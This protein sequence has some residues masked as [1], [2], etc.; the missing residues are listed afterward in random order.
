MKKIKIIGL[1]SVA[2]AAL[3]MSGCGGKN[4]PGHTYMPDMGY[5]RAYETYAGHDSTVITTNPADRG[6]KA[7]FY[8]AMPVAGT[9]KRGELFP[10]TLP[11]DTTGY[12][13]SAKVENPLK[14]M[15]VI[16]LPE[17]ERL[18]MINCAICHGE[19]AAGYGP[20][21]TSGKVPGIANLT[22]PLY[23]AMADGT[24]FHSITYGK[25]FMGSYASQL[26]RKQ[27]WMVI[28]Y[29]RTLQPAPE[30]KPA[31]NAAS[32]DSTVKKG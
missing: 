14:N 2:V 7:I 32:Q 11:N 19:K 20:L 27:R 13:L 29:V 10:Y 15:S 12:R 18:Y 22:S 16:M 31:D 26:D 23:A 17:A 28:N 21:A 4:N 25:G 9:I 3:T 6:G 30:A 1:F 8:N 24:M 5:S